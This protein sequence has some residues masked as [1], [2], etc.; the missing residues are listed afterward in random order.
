MNRGYQKNRKACED[1]RRGE[2]TR[3][4]K[5]GEGLFVTGREE[6]GSPREEERIMERVCEAGNLLRALQAVKNNKGS[7]GED[8]MTVDELPSYVQKH[9]EEIREQLLKGSYQP[10]AVRKVEIPKPDGG[11][12]Q[13]GIPTVKDRFVQQA[14][15]QVLQR[16]LDRK[17]SE[18][19]FG[20]RPG[21]GA[22]GAISKAQEYIAKGYEY[23]V[24]IDIEKFFDCVN[25]DV[26]MSEVYKRMKDKRVLKIIRRFLKSGMVMENGVVSAREKGT[27]QG[28]PLSPLLSNIYLDRLDKELEQRGHGYVRYAD[29]C[30]IY[31]QTPRAAQRVM[32]SI[33]EYIT[34]KLKLKVNGNKSA[35]G[36]YHE[37]KFLGF[38]FMKFK[39]QIKRRIATE[40]IEKFKSRVKQMTH[41]SASRGLDK[42]IEG[43]NQYL[44]GWGGYFEYCQTPTVMEKLNGWIRRR[45]RS[46]LW[47][48][49][50]NGKRRYQELRRLGIKA[51]ELAIA[52]SGLGPWHISKSKAL[53]KALSEEYFRQRGLHRLNVQLKPTY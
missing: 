33:S 37:R 14:I 46:M 25:H 10:K 5:A 15:L 20:F 26:L 21:R 34:K 28:G 23:V 12:R 35:V 31:V 18:N 2:A 27:P 16:K 51:G 50:K 48:Q 11:V 17:F 39:E 32:K 6:E 4:A 44:R 45:L 8:G 30:N 13:L 53:H 24:D 19:S 47:K 43:L 29:D 22:Q 1:T 36:R 41:R 40:S 3:S 42:V 38:S 49:W 9:W 52:G 7:A